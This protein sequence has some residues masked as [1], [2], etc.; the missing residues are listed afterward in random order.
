MEIKEKR[1]RRQ[2]ERI[3]EREEVKG[4]KGKEKR[5]NNERERKICEFWTF[6]S[7]IL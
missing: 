7:E 6:E 5:R 2:E 3:E 4:W 1:V